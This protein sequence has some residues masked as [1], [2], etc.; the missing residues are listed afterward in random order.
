MPQQ[1]AGPRWIDLPLVADWKLASTFQGAGLGSYTGA[2]N[3]TTQ[4]I[5]PSLP[6]RQGLVNLLPYKAAEDKMLLRQ[7]PFLNTVTG[8]T[9]P[10]R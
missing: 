8:S 3:S 5:S 10:P 1:A 7:R 4:F 9:S 2:S 6:R